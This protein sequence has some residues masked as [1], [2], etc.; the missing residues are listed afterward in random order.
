M[1]KLEIELRHHHVQSL[2][3]KRR[4]IKSLKMRL[5]QKF[6]IAIKEENITSF[7]YTNITFATLVLS[8]QEGNNFV[9]KIQQF[10]DNNYNIDI[11]SKEQEYY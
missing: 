9:E 6:N 7:K 3:E 11:N 10:I 5:S 8:E 4:I 2:K 1:L